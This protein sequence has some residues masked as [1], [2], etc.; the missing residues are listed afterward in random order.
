M[1]LVKRRDIAEQK[2]LGRSLWRILGEN[3]PF[4]DE[5][6]AGF[7]RFSLAEGQMVPHMHEREIIYVIDAKGAHTRYGKS[8]EAMHTRAALRPGDL[9]R[10]QEGEWHVFEMDDED[11]Y[12]DIFWVFSCPQNH[13]TE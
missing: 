3:A 1:D 7:A 11:A 13:V 5:V 10:V 6:S 12:L 4:G 9:L 8:K 2:A